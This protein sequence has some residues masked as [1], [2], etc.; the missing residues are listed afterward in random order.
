VTDV[1]RAHG[2][3]PRVA[4][5]TGGA[6]GIG[7]ALALRLAKAG[8]RVA[9]LDW[10]EAALEAVAAESDNLTPMR[11]DVTEDESVHEAIATVREQLGSID[12]VAH[13]AAIM[14][15]ARLAE[16]DTAQIQQMMAVN[17]GGTVNV[18]G[19]VLPEMLSR[20]AGQLVLFGS[21]GGSVLVPECGAY[22][23][24]KAATNAFAEVLIEENRGSGVQIMLVCP[25]LVDTPL[26]EQAVQTSNPKS[27]RDSIANRRFADPEFVVDE[28][29]KGLDRGT[30]I[31]LPGAEAKLVMAARRLAPRLLWKVVK[32]AN[33]E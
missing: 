22:C 10:N 21:T 18:T 16:Q 8:C 4:V 32:R 2:P 17:Y 28:V 7:R 31:L 27:I 13:C 15:T 19:A 26:L 3:P 6:S 20:G 14:P 24:S 25:A 9:V 5:V 33:R 1:Q 12:R 11:C 23:A 30:E 29:E